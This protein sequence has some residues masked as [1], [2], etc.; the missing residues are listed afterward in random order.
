MCSCTC[1]G[2]AT[3][4]VVSAPLP[5]TIISDKYTAR[6]CQIRD[7]APSGDMNRRNSVFEVTSDK[8]YK[9]RMV[10]KR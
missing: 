4:I 7:E 3:I 2:N 6:L 10:G 8:T 5:E 1:T 9:R